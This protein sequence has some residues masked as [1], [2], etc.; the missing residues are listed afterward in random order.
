[1]SSTGPT[2]LENTMCAIDGVWNS[3]IAR[4]GKSAASSAW[5]SER[6][7]KPE[8]WSLTYVLN[9]VLLSSP[10]ET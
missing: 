5:N 4:S 10:S 3:R 2:Q 1:M 9:L 7:S 8:K 6:P